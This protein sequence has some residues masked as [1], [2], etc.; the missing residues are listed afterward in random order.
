MKAIFKTG[1]QIVDADEY[2]TDPDVVRHPKQFMEAVESAVHHL[3]QMDSFVMPVFINL[4]RHHIYFKGLT[5]NYFDTFSGSMMLV[6]SQQLGPDIFDAQTR[7]AWSRLF[8][9]LIQN[10]KFGLKQAI[11]EKDVSMQ[12]GAS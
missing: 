7:T 10:L 6:W 1:Q 8:D 4:G 9:F 2:T 5:E 11:A 12:N 3:D